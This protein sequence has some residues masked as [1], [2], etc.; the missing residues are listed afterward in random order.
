MLIANV[1][2]IYICKNKLIIDTVWRSL[3]QLN[4]LLIHHMKTCLLAQYF[5]LV[6][7]I[8]GIISAN[9]TVSN[10]LLNNISNWIFYPNLPILSLLTQKTLH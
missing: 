5:I 2:H 7:K 9:Q 1:L 3:T 4:I 10:S 6:I 8:T